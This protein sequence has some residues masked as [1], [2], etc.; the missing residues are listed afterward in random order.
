MILIENFITSIITLFLIYFI[1]FL[2][3]IYRHARTITFF[4]LFVYLLTLFLIFLI[5]IY[6]SIKYILLTTITFFKIKIIKIHL[7]CFSLS[8]LLTYG[9]YYVTQDPDFIYL[10]PIIHD[11]IML[12][13]KNMSLA[14]IMYSIVFFWLKIMPKS[15]EHFF[16]ITIYLLVQ[17]IFAGSYY[18]DW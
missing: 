8:F 1:V 10:N 6:C 2:I 14:F 7:L 5:I 16:Q 12:F 3:I 13:T 9:F 15:Q 18:V 17:S 4:N 11:E